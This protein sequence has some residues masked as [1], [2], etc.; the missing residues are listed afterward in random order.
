MEKS[1]SI[2]KVGKHRAARPY[3]I[4]PVLIPHIC[5][6]ECGCLICKK[7]VNDLDEWRMKCK[8]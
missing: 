6:S 3:N 1:T 5:K 2:T 8:K 7:Y 4:K